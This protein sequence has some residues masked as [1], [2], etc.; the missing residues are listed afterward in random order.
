MEGKPFKCFKIKSF[1]PHT[2]QDFFYQYES[3]KTVNFKNK[4]YFSLA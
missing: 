3:T 4:E 1:C 2:E